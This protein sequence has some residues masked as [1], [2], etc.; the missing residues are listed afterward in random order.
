VLEDVVPYVLLCTLLGIV[1]AWVP[2]FL[3]GPIPYKFD[4]FGLSGSWAVWNW[5]T[6]RMLIGFMV[7]ISTWPRLWCLRG[8]LVGFLMLLPPGFV[9][10]GNPMCGPPCVFWN[11]VSAIGIGVVVA[12]IARW[13]TGRNHRSDDGVPET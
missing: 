13:I 5:Y 4:A 8:A 9:S 10:M 6:A 12:G 7:G 2:S 3:H 1:A 11:E